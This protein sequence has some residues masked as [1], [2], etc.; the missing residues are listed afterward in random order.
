MLLSVAV[1]TMVVLAF[2][3][4]LFILV[5]DLASDTAVSAAERDAESLARVFAV[6]VLDNSLEEA[7]A[8]YGV[9]RIV[10]ISGTVISPDGET[11]GLELSEDEDLTPALEGRSFVVAVAAGAAVF[12][13]LLIDDGPPA[14]IRVFVSQES[15]TAGVA[16]SRF[17][18]GLLGL[19][20]IVMAAWIA[21][22][23]SR[24]IVQPINTLS[25]TVV[26]LGTGDLDVRVEP[27]GPPEVVQMGVEFNRLAEQV[28]RLLQE[29][30]ESAADLAHRLRTPLTS[31]RLSAEALA[32][33][34][35]RDRLVGAVDDL[36]RTVDFIIT[37]A[38][39]PV[40]Q[41]TGGLC[42]LSEVVTTRAAFW[43]PLASEQDR[44][45]KLEAPVPTVVHVP[46]ADVEAMV[47]ALIENVL[48]HTPDGS[49]FSLSVSSAG[50]MARLTVEDGGLGI[51]DLD[52]VERGV[53][54][55]DSTGLGL[56]IVRRTAESAGGSMKL[57][58]SELGGLRVTVELLLES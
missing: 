25:D 40:R 29:E 3:V 20:L 9:D 55:G 6:L 44:S 51:A 36:H 53:S 13:P 22:R 35:E 21:D 23:L 42:D 45:I 43:E 49:D 5:S 47:D 7:V 19:T 41:E 57:S 14:I 11:F 32:P 15:I 39:R 4:P 56:D 28:A 34:T 33:S 17:L 31:A 26:L 30:R 1:A 2:I 50:N 54:T 52:L 38:R 37:E 24:E 10:A 16:R 58:V 12:I 46:A 18:L 27:S 48:S 8:V